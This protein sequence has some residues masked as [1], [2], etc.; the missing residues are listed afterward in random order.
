MVQRSPAELTLANMSVTGLTVS[1]FSSTKDS[2]ALKRRL[3]RDLDDSIV[4]AI[5]IQ[6]DLSLKI[7]NL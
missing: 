6:T 7:Q 3:C 4:K 2:P 5:P 1:W